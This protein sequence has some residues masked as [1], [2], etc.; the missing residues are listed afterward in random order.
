MEEQKRRL[1]ARAA[2]AA[3]WSITRVHRIWAG[4]SEIMKEIVGRALLK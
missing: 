2:T 4:T 1:L 3:R